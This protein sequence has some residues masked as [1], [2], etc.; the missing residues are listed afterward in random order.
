M[1]KALAVACFLVLVGSLYGQSVAE[2]SRQERARRGGLGANR[3]KVV[4]NADLA[5]VR[6][7]PA[8]S[9]ASADLSTDQ[10]ATSVEGPDA[11]GVIPPGAGGSSEPVVMVPTV[12]RD[13]P[14]LYGPGAVPG[15]PATEKDLELQL[16]A[17]DE[18]VDLLTNKMNMLLQESNDLNSMT[19][20]DVIMQQVDDTS[21]KL[22]KAQ[23][24]DAK[25][26]TQLDAARK[27]TPG[28]H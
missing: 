10:N 4:T 5:A 8:I 23:D 13:G 12:I 3:A 21:Q 19:P 18:L 20:R 27:N 1:K 7:T 22:A 16:K 26:K 6:K 11:T 15:P 9:T 17:A 24:D 14:A 2:L 25:L 28:R